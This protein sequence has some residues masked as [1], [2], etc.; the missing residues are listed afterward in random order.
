MTIIGTAGHV[1]HGKS[2]LVAALTGTHPDRLAEERRRGL[3]IDLGFAHAT[4]PSGAD[5]SVVDVPGH[6]RF[7]HNMLAG[8]G[9]VSGCLF[10]VDAKEGWKPQSEEHLRILELLDVPTGVVAVTKADLVGAD[11]LA[12]TVADVAG[13]VAGTFLADAPRIPVSVVDGTGMAELVAALEG[14]CA[15]APPVPD[16][17]RPRLWVDRV[18]TAAGSGTVVTGTLTDGTLAVGDEVSIAP[19]GRTARIRAIQTAGATLDTALPGTRVA[20]N[21][22][23]VDHYALSRGDAVVG[24]QRWLP[25]DRCDASLRVLDSVGHDVTRRG[26]YVV[27]TGTAEVTARLR[28]VGSADA[29]AAGAEGAV[30]LHLARPLPLRPGDRYEL[31]ESGRGET[32]GGG[33]VLDLAPV[34]PVRRASPNRSLD[35]LVSERGWVTADDVEALTGERI[36]PVVGRWVVALD[37]LAALRTELARRVEEAGVAGLDVAAL[38]ERE[39]AVLDELDVTIERG[40]ARAA[41]ATDR[42]AAHSALA[43]LRAGGLMPDDPGIARAEVRELVHRGLA[44]ERDGILFHPDAIAAAAGVAASLLAVRPDGF[45]VAEFRDATGTTRKFALPLVA[46]LDARAV[47]RR[48]G[49]RHIAGPRLPPVTDPASDA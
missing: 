11:E 14:V 15:T 46:E 5:I 36:T 28:V 34:L 35:R 7:L 23:G 19:G 27:H 9:A 1:D 49:D 48:R 18:F 16:R 3:S 25:T 45:T 47:T 13:R 38:D 42:F 2:T 21:L 44:V 41:A 37:A 31:R 4:L 20:L 6:V 40:V 26:A 22:A 43:D 17:G 30:R 12:T 24:P 32:V 39:R 8:V 29:V 33:E 10:V